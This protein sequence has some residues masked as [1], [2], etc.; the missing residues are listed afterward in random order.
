VDGKKFLVALAVHN[1]SN[2]QAQNLIFYWQ[3]IVAAFGSEYL[4]LAYNVL[5]VHHQVG[6]KVLQINQ[7][8]C[9]NF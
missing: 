9:C 7:D 6:M 5:V 2:E 3:L 4:L 1:S 8:W